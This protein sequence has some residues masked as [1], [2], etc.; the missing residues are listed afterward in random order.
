MEEPAAPTQGR[1]GAA[2]A[3]WRTVP[4]RRE[5]RGPGVP[6]PAPFRAP[7]ARPAWASAGGARAWPVPGRSGGS[8]TRHIA[9]RYYLHGRCKE[10]PRCRYSH[11]A[12]GRPEQ[13][14]GEAPG[15]V[16]APTT[17]AEGAAA[18]PSPPIGSAPVLQ[19]DVRGAD[20]G[21][22]AVARATGAGGW[23]EAVEFVPGRP[24]WGRQL[25]SAPEGPRPI[26][27]PRPCPATERPRPLCRD[28]A[29][30]QCFRGASCLYVHGDV[31]DMCGLQALHPGDAVQRAAHRR[32]C[33]DAHERDM[34]LSFAVQRSRDKVCGIC[35]ETVFERAQSADCRF[36]ILSNCTHTF[37]LTCIRRWRTATQFE[38]RIIKSCPQCRVASSFVIPSQF[39]VE[40]EQE[41]RQLIGQYKE[42]M[43]H[44][45]CRYF[46]KGRRRCPFG[47]KCFYQHAQPQ[48]PGEEPQGQEAPSPA[49]GRRGSG[50][51]EPE[52]VGEGS[53]VIQSCHHHLVTLLLCSKWFLGRGVKVPLG[54]LQ[55][56]SVCIVALLWHVVWC[57]EML[58]WPA[59]CS[60]KHTPSRP[61]VSGASIAVS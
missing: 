28:A 57:A 36:G 6:G 32:A 12:A 33:L 8:W 14:S 59:A 30:G 1:E 31:C 42:A 61:H 39:W 34:E 50:L 17:R 26:P 25:L 21:D 51:A 2:A 58:S 29:L 27:E 56:A 45:A 7:R 46:A 38:N 18:R 37:C 24:Y 55:E 53:I 19:D 47:D 9:C 11:D 16:A 43:S 20:L 41:K 60:H 35:M 5:L 40:E 15:A 4:A 44:K 10:G 13:L 3:P 49:T 22:A 23:E 52:Q 48:G 54:E